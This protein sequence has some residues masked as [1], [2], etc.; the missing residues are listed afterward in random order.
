MI[1]KLSF[2][3]ITFCNIRSSEF[4]Q[5]IE[6]NGLFTFPAAPTLA[7]LKNGSEYHNA[8]INSNFVFFD[9]G[10][11]VLLLRL[12]KNIKVIKFSG[13]KF[14]KLLF[15][16]LKKNNEKKLFLVNPS[17]KSSKINEKYLRKLGICNIKNYE[18]PIY[19]INSIEDYNLLRLIKENQPDYV[20]INLGGGVQE[21]LGYFLKKKITQ[22]IKIFCTGGAISYFTGE[23]APINK[24]IDEYYLGWLYRIIFNPKVFINRYIKSFKLL[25]DVHKEDIKIL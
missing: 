18:S 8:L 22:N 5:I 6:K 20:I 19:N 2:K 14:L 3:N 12:L 23:Q 21:V 25:K 4:T 10:Y 17:S 1:K 24:F 15:T 16:F 9:S 13:Y 7:D 11:F